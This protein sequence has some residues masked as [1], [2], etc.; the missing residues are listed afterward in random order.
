MPVGVE[1]YGPNGAVLVS[2]TSKIARQL[3]AVS[4]GTTDGSHSDPELGSGVPWIASMPQGSPS[5]NNAPMVILSGT[6]IS[7]RFTAGMPG[8]RVTVTIIYGVR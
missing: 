2:Y 8:E 7:W 1:T 3:G 5:H 4:T 6:T